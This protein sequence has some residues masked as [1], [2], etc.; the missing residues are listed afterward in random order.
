MIPADTTSSVGTR[1]PHGFTLLELLV[2]LTVFGFLMV[3]LAQ[4]LH[5][6]LLS[7][8]TEVRLSSRNEDLD[9][10]DTTVRHLIEGADPGNDADTAPFVGSKDRFLCITAL[11]S[12]AGAT[13][14]RRIQ[15]ELLVDASHRLVLR[16]RPYVHARALRPSA[17][18]T[19][20]ELLHGISEIQL[21]FWQPGAGWVNV[22]RAPSL[23]TLVRVRLRFPQADPRHWPDIV[24]APMLDRP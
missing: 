23:P 1:H 2:A 3:G 19:E 5:F 7:W 18:F 6:G 11:P 22:W 4:G 15:A 14:V 10:V 9:P 21:A 16:W 24:A 13:G 20:S 12:A 17:A 8:V